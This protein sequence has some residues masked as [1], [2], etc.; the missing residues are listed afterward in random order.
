[1]NDAEY[2]NK[3][4][5]N[6]G[7]RRVN[8]GQLIMNY[9]HPIRRTARPRK[10][11]LLLVVLSLLVLF[12]LAG[13]TFMVVAGQY[14]RVSIPMLQDERTGDPPKQQ[15]ETAM[16][17]LL[18]DTNNPNSAL[19][20]HSL[21]LDK[22][23]RGGIKATVTAVFDSKKTAGAGAVNLSNLGPGLSLQ[24]DSNDIHAIDVTF[25]SG[26]TVVDNELTGREIT[27]ITG[28]AKGGT[29]RIVA[30]LEE[31]GTNRLFFIP[32]PGDSGKDIPLVGDR[33][34]I[35]DAPFNGTGAGFDPTTGLR[36]SDVS[37]G[38]AVFP[39]PRAAHFLNHAFLTRWLITTGG[40]LPGVVVNAG[41]SDESWDAADFDNLFLAAT[42]QNGSVFMNPT[43]TP[44]APKEFR[45]LPSF[46]R[47]DLINY[48]FRILA[49]T[50][51]DL[52]ASVTSSPEF[53]SLNHPKFGPDSEFGASTETVYRPR[54]L[55]FLRALSL[56]PLRFDHPNF[57][58]S[59]P[60]YASHSTT[61]RGLR[62]DPI[63]G[64][65]DVDNDG[66]GDFDS[67]WIDLGLPPQSTKSG[68]MYKPLF[69]ILVRDMDGRVNVNYA[70]N[71]AQTEASSTNFDTSAFPA[72]TTINLD[73][74]TTTTVTLPRGIGSGPAE[75]NLGALLVNASLGGNTITQV[76][77]NNVLIPRYGGGSAAAPGDDTYSDFRISLLYPS[78]RNYSGVSDYLSPPDI[79]G[80]NATFQDHFGTPIY[81]NDPSTLVGGTA[82]D[83]TFNIPY[84]LDPYRH[85]VTD[86]NRRDLLFTEAELERLLR[87]RDRDRGMYQ[88]VRPEW[89]T[90]SNF[91][92]S[93]NAANS[94]TTRSFDVPSLPRPAYLAGSGAS[95]AMSY[96]ETPR[97][98]FAERLE[99]AGVTGPA[100]QVGIQAM[101]PF[102]FARG[103]RMD[104][105]RPWGNGL[106]D[107]TDGMVDDYDE[108]TNVT[109]GREKFAALTPGNELPG[110][111]P[112]N[113]PGNY[114]NVYNSSPVPRVSQR[115]RILF[116]RH[117]YCLAMFLLDD[118]FVF[119][120]ADA[121]I[122]PAERKR[123]T[124]R[125][126]AQWAINVVDYRDADLVMT[127]FEYDPNPYDGWGVDDDLSTIEPGGPGVRDVVW[128]CET[129]VLL[130][131][132]SLAFHDRRV[133][134]TDQELAG[135]LRNQ[136]A[137][138]DNQPDDADLDQTRIPQGSLILE[139]YCPANNNQLYTKSLDLFDV[140][141]RLDLGKLSPRPQN[142]SSSAN[143]GVPV[144][145]IA[146][147]RP[148]ADILPVGGNPYVLPADREQIVAQ[149]DRASFQPADPYYPIPASQFDEIER[150]VWFTNRDP[151]NVAL[152]GTVD[153]SSP[154][155]IQLNANTFY[156]RNSDISEPL[157]RYMNDGEFK[158]VLPRLATY[159]GEKGVGSAAELSDQAIIYDP[160]VP[161]VRFTDLD[162]ITTNEATI[163]GFHLV[164]KADE[165][166]AL[167]TWTTLRANAGSPGY[168]NYQ[169]GI[170][171]NVTEPVIGSD[172][173]KAPTAEF[174][175]APRAVFDRYSTP[176]D[177]PFDSSPGTAG[178]TKK[179]VDYSVDP[180]IPAQRNT[181]WTG[182]ESKEALRRTAYLQRLADPN[183]AYDPLIN[184]Y[185]TVDWI[186]IDV[187][188]FNGSD[189]QMELAL[190][191]VPPNEYLDPDDVSP[192]VTA[193]A[194]AQGAGIEFQPPPYFA[195]RLRG[196]STVVGT[197]AINDIWSSRTS[198]AVTLADSSDDITADPVVMADEIVNYNVR[199]DVD[200]G[201]FRDSLSHTSVASG[202]QPLPWLNAANRPYVS[203]LDLMLVPSSSPD[204]VSFEYSLST[205]AAAPSPYD[206]YGQAPAAAAFR[207]APFG[208]LLNFFN[209]RSGTGS[210]PSPPANLARIF[211][212]LDVPSRFVGTQHHFLSP[213]NVGGTPTQL[214]F[215]G[216]WAPFNR[217]ST[218]RE[219]GKIN[220]NT[221][222]DQN[223]WNA[224][225]SGYPDHVDP[226][227]PGSAQTLGKFDAFVR[228]RQGYELP[229]TIALPASQVRNS[230]ALDYQY[231]SVFHK[232]FAAASTSGLVPN[233]TLNAGVATQPTYG[234][235]STLLRSS[236]ASPTPLFGPETAALNTYDNPERNPGFAYAGIQRLA[237]MTTTQSNVFAVWITIG[238]FEVSSWKDLAGNAVIDDAHPDGLQLGRELGEATGDIERHRAFYLIDRSIP[239]AFEPG[240]NH[241]VD[242]AVIIRR[243]IE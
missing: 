150:L 82:F 22:Y 111:K 101:M 177:N 18:R 143:F 74:S 225:M 20:G 157:A 184:P 65:W 2:C 67:V 182:Q 54:E 124:S 39:S 165:P 43:G 199:F 172:Y 80:R 241:N 188:V 213:T 167:A 168:E 33:V 103:E 132:E 32:L 224:L 38:G 92:I 37:I 212:F 117:L 81:V 31:S 24:I 4:A 94:V 145:R 208:H 209:R 159:I 42:L 17:E 63:N 87:Y 126:I 45:T 175:V 110:N 72:A 180:T 88:S 228:S 26:L 179:L 57:T 75:I 46:H 226:I 41:G 113:V 214:G 215:D 5:R 160:S 129:P 164:C 240:Q 191:Q 9:R 220:L 144:W 69:A 52:G 1:M 64:P 89:G 97:A 127:G 86:P 223:V 48:Y 100:V 171:L 131:T 106:D 201:G 217:L 141:G 55:N 142:S 200:L 50:D 98:L 123:L 47:P 16:Y 146:L 149:V 59:N 34:M 115:A 238:Y 189:G 207:A 112:L 78:L 161:G 29:S 44:S 108:D 178:T 211:D 109:D 3:I 243:F 242:D 10:G 234:S 90:I 235:D 15:L 30:N 239:V 60:A 102:E 169:P 139:L 125:R 156:S 218:M 95:A 232:P 21:F 163:G 73:G 66:D 51:S 58:G 231:P 187:I 148:F 49:G 181:L 205:V 227:E 219:P 185:L 173:Y 210:P 53:A 229:T 85:D 70:G 155:V 68:R 193:L 122:T 134:D 19:A 137:N 91:L 186:S 138:S 130:L 118:E 27:A 236:I 230:Y 194:T 154:A 114:D 233:P 121:A 35:N 204:R 7:A 162:P 170:G 136:N 174:G 96:P 25:D 166:S 135:S 176:E 206:S 151:N 140:N 62:F 8:Q 147:S 79:F 192:T 36:T 107:D 56:R 202:G 40:P 237:N 152:P 23:G 128:G 105:N 222:Y 76:I 28:Q 190:S 158:L 197:P 12:V 196:T 11:V 183:S 84:E 153:T 61:H 77:E 13:M 221:I 195:S 99:A 203:E 116:A 83:E 14:R 93:A 120:T 71:L 104:V 119:P 133:K 6:V 198:P 216:F